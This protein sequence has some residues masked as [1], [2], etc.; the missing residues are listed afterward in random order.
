M[1]F[2]SLVR[3]LKTFNLNKISTRLNMERIVLNNP[4]SDF[5]KELD[6]A[7]QSTTDKPLFLLFTGAKN[8]DTGISW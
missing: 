4:V 1:I 7:I 5:D 8:K 6:K 2:T 3:G